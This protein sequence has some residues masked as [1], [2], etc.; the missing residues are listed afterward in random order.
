MKTK[1]LFSIVWA[2]FLIFNV[3]LPTTFAQ[4][5]TTWNL[6][7]GAKARLG[8]GEITNVA[9]SPDGNSIAVA[10]H[11][12][13]WLYDAQN[14]QELSL[15]TGHTRSIFSLAFSPDGQ[16]LASGSRDKTIRLWDVRTGEHKKTFRGH[17]WFVLSIDFSP[18]GQTLANG[19]SDGTIHLWDVRTGK[20]KQT[21]QG[22][23]DWL[24]SEDFSPDGQ[25]QASGSDDKT[26]C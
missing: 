7:E 9:Y 23:T 12:G 16:T 17:T 5:Y 8:K 18:D 22:H 13:I 19:S 21:L 14:Y 3:H 1:F 25:T 20:H 26:N 10:T 6:P 15:L 2:G 11:I 24:R 4:D